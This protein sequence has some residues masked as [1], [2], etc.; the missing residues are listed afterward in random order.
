MGGKRRNAQPK[1]YNVM[2]V[3]IQHNQ[4][5]FKFQAYVGEKESYLSYRKEPYKTLEY[6]ETFVPESLRG[7]GIASKI[8]DFALNH[9]K[10][11][12]YKVIATCPFV[13][14]YIDEHEEYAELI[15]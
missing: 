3:T 13:A 7:K 12:G 5:K 15:K 11:N 14:N 4:K 6:Y 8:V 9:A 10:E 1:T 2:N